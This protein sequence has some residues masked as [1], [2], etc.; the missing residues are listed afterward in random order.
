MGTF[1]NVNVSYLGLFGLIYVNMFFSWINKFPPEK[2]KET[3][4]FWSFISF[5]FPENHFDF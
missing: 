4:Y 2:I 1:K 3:I 5:A